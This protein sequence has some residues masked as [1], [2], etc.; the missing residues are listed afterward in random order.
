MCGKKNDDMKTYPKVMLK[1]LKVMGDPTPIYTPL[2]TYFKEASIKASIK[3][4][5]CALT[6]EAS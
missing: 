1:I 6:K 5:M 4:S 3:A 2:G